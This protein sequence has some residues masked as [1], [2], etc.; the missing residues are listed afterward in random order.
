MLSGKFWKRGYFGTKA[1]WHFTTEM[2]RAHRYYG[3]MDGDV[4]ALGPTRMSMVLKY[5][6]CR[7][8][9]VAG[10]SWCGN[11]SDPRC[12]QRQNV[13]VPKCLCPNLSG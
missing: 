7:Y 6:Q 13:H 1:F 10:P 9:P 12:L 5:S 11:I 3:T 2:F 4:V 8:I